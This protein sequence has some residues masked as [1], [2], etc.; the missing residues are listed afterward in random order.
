MSEEASYQT[1]NGAFRGDRSSWAEG[2]PNRELVYCNN[3][4]WVF[5]DILTNNRYG[6]GQFVDENL[7]DKYSLFEIAKYCDELVSDGEG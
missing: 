3:P 6:V 7:I 4:A 1:W 2:H 5:Y